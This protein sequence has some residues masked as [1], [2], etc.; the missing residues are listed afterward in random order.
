MPEAPSLRSVERIVSSDHPPICEGEFRF[1]QLVDHLKSYKAPMVVSIGEDA[2]RLISRVEYDSVTNC[3]V[4][5]VLPVDDHGIPKCDRFV[6]SSF[7]TIEEA[8]DVGTKSKFAFLYYMAQPV[9]ENIPAFCLSCQGTDNKFTAD[10]VLKR[11]KTIYTQCKLRGITV[12]SFGADGD[13]QI[14]SFAGITQF[15][16]GV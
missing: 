4:G 2:T 9:R 15:R 12:L 14:T 5:F 3:L 6:A 1:D 10:L 8:F 7:E 11:W 16:I 13:P